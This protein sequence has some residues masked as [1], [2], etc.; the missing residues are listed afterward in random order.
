MEQFNGSKSKQK[1]NAVE[2]LWLKDKD[3]VTDMN[4]KYV[5]EDISNS[6]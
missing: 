5:L 3:L 6:I 2:W 4:I 1:E